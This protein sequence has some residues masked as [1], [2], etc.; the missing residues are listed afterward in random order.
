MKKLPPSINTYI[1]R[2]LSHPVTDAIRNRTT[3]FQAFSGQY[4]SSDLHAC[5]F[6]L[7]TKIMALPKILGD[8][9]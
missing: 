9:Y 5:N 3:E 1:F 2:L 7:K 6:F 8:M 4:G